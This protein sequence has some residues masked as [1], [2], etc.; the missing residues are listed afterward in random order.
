MT[1]RNS[2]EESP[3]RRQFME[4]LAGGALA[5]MTTAR[6]ADS[7]PAAER[8]PTITLGKHSV[9]RLIAGSNPMSGYSHSVPKLDAIMTDWFTRERM[10]DFVRRCERNGINTWQTNTFPKNMGA[11]RE[12]RDSGSKMQWICLTSDVDAAKWKEVAALKPIAVVHH[13]STT[14]G[15]FRTGEEGKIRDFVKKV[16]DLGFLAGIS[17]HS[18]ENITRCEESNWEQDLY[19]TCFYNVLRDKAQVKTSLGDATVDEMY[20]QQDPAR[21]TAVVRQVKRPCLG[22][23]ILAAGRMCV[24]RPSIQRAFNFAYSNIKK[25]D[26]VIVGMFP[27]LTDEIAEDAEIARWSTSSI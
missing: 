22:F 19:M 27:I 5:A 26:A 14:D 16:H 10:L 2:K 8:L 11:L 24:N 17:S 1:H 20:L 4:K 3:G 23:K 6:A 25:T 12:A 18:P 7:A 15:L 13:G 21:M 9:T